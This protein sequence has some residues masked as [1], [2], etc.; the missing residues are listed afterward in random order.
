M[1]DLFNN[2]VKF[3]N[4]NPELRDDI[5]PVLHHLKNLSKDKIARVEDMSL[6]DYK[7][8]FEKDLLA[9][10]MKEL[11]R[12]LGP[13]ES[14]SMRGSVEFYGIA[15]GKFSELYCRLDMKEKKVLCRYNHPEKT[16]TEHEY[17][18]TSLDYISQIVEM[19]GEEVSDVL[20][21]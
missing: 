13:F 4:N 19:V 14:S 12:I 1:K 7:K 6:K 5:K 18:F 16:Q 3:G 2:L 21:G 17:N 15:D 8:K 20:Y 11:E 10:L 9:E